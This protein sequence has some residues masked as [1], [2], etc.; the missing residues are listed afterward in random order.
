[1]VGQFTN[2][3]SNSIL[4][5]LWYHPRICLDGPNKTKEHH[6]KAVRIAGLSQY[7]NLTPPKDKSKSITAKPM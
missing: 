2:D 5:W 1:M 7:S 6:E 4:K 3:K